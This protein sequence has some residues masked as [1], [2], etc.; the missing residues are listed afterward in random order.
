LTI[1][2]SCAPPNATLDAL[3]DADDDAERLSLADADADGEFETDGLTELDGLGER[4]TDADGLL[5]IS[6]MATCTAARSSDVPEE[7]PT[8]RD[9]C[10]AV[11]SWTAI[12][13]LAPKSID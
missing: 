9:P 4:E 10:P 5:M 12:A 6:R 2:T 11:V 3:G 13:P 7:K 8:E 1:G